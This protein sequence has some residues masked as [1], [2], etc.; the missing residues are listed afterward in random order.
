[1]SH[2]RELL[3]TWK[4]CECCGKLKNDSLSRF[5]ILSLTERILCLKCFSIENMKEYN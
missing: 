3:A 4:R 2:K 5:M 1:M